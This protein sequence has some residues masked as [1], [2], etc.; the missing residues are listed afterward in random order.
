MT[1]KFFSGY[2]L[3]KYLYTGMPVE[4]NV[5]VMF[6]GFKLVEGLHYR[7]EYSDNIDEGIASA[8]IIGIGMFYGTK[9]LRF[10][11][12]KDAGLDL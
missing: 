1:C 5:T 11:V 12:S 6:R 8:K 4:P 7:I 2:G 10:L 3:R 9:T